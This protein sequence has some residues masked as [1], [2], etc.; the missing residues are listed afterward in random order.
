[1]LG[2]RIAAVSLVDYLSHS[3]HVVIV[4]ADRHAQYQIGRIAGHV[5][6]F[7]VEARVLQNNTKHRTIILETV[8]LTTNK[9][10]RY[11]IERHPY[12]YQ[13]RFQEERT[14]HFVKRRRFF[15]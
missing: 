8:Q 2:K 15:K 5:I 4:A 7:P 12:C 6:D 1:V 9:V 10:I 14:G 11:T 3:D 13:R